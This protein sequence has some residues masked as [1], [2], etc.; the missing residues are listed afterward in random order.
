MLI[1]QP[2]E[3]TGHLFINNA[4]LVMGNYFLQIAK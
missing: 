3:E 1:F 4:T 2:N